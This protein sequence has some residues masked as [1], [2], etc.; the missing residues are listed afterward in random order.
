MEKKFKDMKVIYSGWMKL[1]KVM[2]GDRWYE[3][4]KN[5]DAVAAIVRDKDGKILLVEQFRPALLSNTLEVPAGCIDK[6]NKSREEIMREELIE[7]AGLEVPI[8]KI[9]ECITYKPIVGFSSS[10]MHIYEIQLDIVGENRKIENDDV[11]GTRW[12]TMD[13]IE[14]LIKDE[15]I[16]DSKTIMSYFYLK[17]KKGD[18][19]I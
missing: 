11:T 7:E 1:F 8:E 14:N 19:K 17:G 16:V 2:V 6:E 18:T 4:L 12:V 3:Y 5:H 9:K 13:Q 10:T 15:R